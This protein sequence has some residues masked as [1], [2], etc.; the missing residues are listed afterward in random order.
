MTRKPTKP[1]KNLKYYERNLE[2]LYCIESLS[3]MNCIG[4]HIFKKLIYFS[5]TLV[6]SLGN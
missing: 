2:F 5:K 4:K 6:F 1:S 3:S